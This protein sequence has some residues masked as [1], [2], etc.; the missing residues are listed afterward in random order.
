MLSVIEEGFKKAIGGNN[1]E[2]PKETDVIEFL[3]TLT[4]DQRLGMLQ[5]AEDEIAD[6]EEEASE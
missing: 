3:G 4:P 2:G 5:A 1:S 6:S